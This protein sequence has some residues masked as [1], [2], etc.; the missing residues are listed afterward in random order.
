MPV[1]LGKVCAAL[2]IQLQNCNIICCLVLIDAALISIRVGLT[3]LLKRIGGVVDLSGLLG[4]GSSSA[5]LLNGVPGG[6]TARL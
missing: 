5:E 2:L 1:F 3:V 6:G 4:V